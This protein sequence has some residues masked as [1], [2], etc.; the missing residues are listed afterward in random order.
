MH[1]KLF[2]NLRALL[3]DS[4]GAQH[5]S[6]QISA[7]LFFAFELD[8]D[9]YTD[10][11]LPYLERCRLPTFF[12]LRDDHAM[13]ARR[14][15]PAGVK[16]EVDPRQ[17]CD[18]DLLVA[19]MQAKLELSQLV[20]RQLVSFLDAENLGMSTLRELTCSD[21]ELTLDELALLLMDPRLAELERFELSKKNRLAQRHRQGPELIDALE[22]AAFRDSITSLSL[23]NQ[24]IGEFGALQLARSKHFPNLEALDLS[25]NRLSWGALES[26]LTSPTR[27]KLRAVAWGDADLTE[28]SDVPA[29]ATV[30]DLDLLSLPRCVLDA[31]TLAALPV[32]LAPTKVGS[33][34]LQGCDLSRFSVDELEQFLLAMSPRRVDLRSAR[35]GLST[36]ASL[37]GSHALQHLR[38]DH[39]H[40]KLMRVILAPGVVDVDL[41]RS[42]IDDEGV[43]LLVE[44][45]SLTG[46]RTL[47][48]AGNTITDEGMRLIATADLSALTSLELTHHKSLSRVGAW[49]LATATTAR[50]DLSVS[51][52]FTESFER[53]RAFSRGEGVLNLSG[54]RGIHHDVLMLSRAG[55]FDGAREVNL[56]GAPLSNWTVQQLATHQGYRY[57]VCFD[58]SDAELSAATALA[59]VNVGGRHRL[60]RRFRALETF[61]SDA[62]ITALEL[63]GWD[64]DDVAVV[65][66]CNLR[67]LHRV[68]RL[69]L[70]GSNLHDAWFAQLLAC[71]EL[72][73]LKTLLLQD[74][75]LTDSA[76]FALVNSG[77]LARLERLDIRGTS[78]SAFA[79]ALLTRR[80]NHVTIRSDALIQPGDDHTNPA[81]LVSALERYDAPIRA[82]YV[83]AS[84]LVE[85]S[86]PSSIEA[87]CHRFDALETPSQK[88]RFAALV[89]AGKSVEVILSKLAMYK[90]RPA[91]QPERPR[92]KPRAAIIL[93]QLD[94]RDLEDRQRERGG[95]VHSGYHESRCR[96]SRCLPILS[97]QERMNP[98]DV[99]PEAVR[100]L[101]GSLFGSTWMRSHHPPIGDE[102][103]RIFAA[104]ISARHVDSFELSRNGVTSAG[105]LHLLT[106]P[107]L[108]RV[109]YLGLGWNALGDEGLTAIAESPR[110]AR[111]QTL[112]LVCND[113]SDVG[114]RAL[115]K[116]SAMMTLRELD[117]RGNSISLSAFLEF[118]AAHECS[119]ELVIRSDFDDVD[120]LWRG[121][122]VE[123]LDLSRRRL[124]D[125]D[126]DAL[127]ELPGLE[128]LSK[129]DVRSNLFTPL[130]L[131]RLRDHPELAA[132]SVWSYQNLTESA[133]GTKL[134]LSA[135]R[136]RSEQQ[137]M[138]VLGSWDSSALTHLCFD[139]AEVSDHTA[140]QL[141]MLPGL[142]TLRELD[143]R[144]TSITGR[145]VLAL[146][147]SSSL[148]ALQSISAPEHV[149]SASARA[150]GALAMHPRAGLIDFDQTRGSIQLQ[151]TPRG[152]TVSF[153]SSPVTP[154]ILGQLTHELTADPLDALALEHVG[155]TDSGFVELVTSSSAARPRHLRLDGNPITDEGLAE[156][157]GAAF[158]RDVT[159]LSLRH[160]SVGSRGVEALAA[161]MPRLTHVELM[162]HQRANDE[163]ATRD[164]VALIRSLEPVARGLEHLDLTHR[165][166]DL[167][168]IRAIL[169]VGIAPGL[170]SLG[171][172]EC[173]WLG[174][175]SAVL[176]ANSPAFQSLERL[177]VSGMREASAASV[178]ELL[179]SEHLRE[180]RE[181][182]VS[183]PSLKRAHIVE[184]AEVRGVYRLETLRLRDVHVS[185]EVLL[186]L[187][188]APWLSELSHLDISGFKFD[189][190]R[191][192]DIEPF[193]KLLTSSRL[194]TIELWRS[195]VPAGIMRIIEERA[196]STMTRVLR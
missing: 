122:H 68:E 3:S 86:P 142:T 192:G 165:N 154:A 40:T 31:S 135:D 194:Q 195:W 52:R 72:V 164:S 67:A 18:L 131:E 85:D 183:M 64:F 171:L 33:L 144:A 37:L 93:D 63:I 70:R 162:L 19:P 12:F 107:H 128:R 113:I 170:K 79:L 5:K 145:G 130:G 114:L 189:H 41:S 59:L 17:G 124:D 82:A 176:I 1:D 56:S 121:E 172:G 76:A 127:L 169:D 77:A 100:A 106:S 116:S 4:I 151:T 166:V 36:L 44:S 115:G 39:Q 118:I 11:W 102:G 141:A 78:T 42:M 150:R 161:S 140:R 156:V 185:V 87:L 88:L 6:A 27:A 190:A 103:L 101:L 14:W 61:M 16:I 180:L 119:R 125:R 28:V 133:W 45:G 13:K 74:T 84:G 58:V 163:A 81:L 153:S 34:G 20:S 83:M 96:C 158:F 143:L 48:L 43:R 30:R 50:E 92:E 187:L 139:G 159:S 2:G 110:C 134:I 193:R 157:R 129:L 191:D 25:D 186:R 149:A 175:Q 98:A 71:G 9:R 109:R 47:N 123:D 62:K 174:R 55:C 181:L 137:L 66:L 108:E 49:H 8:P 146:L 155:L 23:R 136:A 182:D 104:S 148:P 152:R 38:I 69:D 89:L 196:E 29:R 73:N 147:D 120:A 177:D 57:E 97:R 7:L 132:C 54:V 126:L 188:D 117:L 32:C 53:F 99:R 46:V 105:I 178:R 111:L 167:D 112:V 26:L 179:E 65:S 94:A 90:T 24:R 184:L 15:L 21:P 51:W 22:R 91:R 10:Q 75:A 95:E 168:G 80:A 60:P 160:V 35:L 173:S 138:D